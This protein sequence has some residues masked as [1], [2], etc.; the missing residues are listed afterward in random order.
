MPRY[1]NEERTV[2]STTKLGQFD[3]HIQRKG[4]RLLPH[5][6]HTNLLKMDHR[7]KCENRIYDKQRMNLNWE[8]KVMRIQGKR[9]IVKR[10]QNRWIVGFRGD[11]R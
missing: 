8:R 11:K 7:P 5:L 6:I 3:D 10:K 4:V 2:F 9:G 1:F